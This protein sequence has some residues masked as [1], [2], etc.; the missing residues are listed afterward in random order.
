M[1]KGLV[2]AA[3]FLTGC[4]P[5]IKTEYITVKVPVRCE[6]ERPERPIKQTDP[7][8]G[9]IDILEYTALLEIALDECGEGGKQ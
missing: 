6:A 8:L 3:A 2:L 5:V 1:I 7:I 4:A 9:L